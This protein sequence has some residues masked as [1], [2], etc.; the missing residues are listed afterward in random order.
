MTSEENIRVLS[1]RVTAAPEDSEEFRIAMEELRAALAASAARGH[2][3]IAALQK[4]L[5][6]SET[7]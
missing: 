6:H 1:Q 7:N 4:A 3:K 5:P 2:A